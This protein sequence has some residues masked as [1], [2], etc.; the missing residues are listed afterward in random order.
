MQT[1]LSHIQFN[2]QPDHLPFYTELLTFLGW[3]T[4]C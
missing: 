1:H 4:C 3:H 2:V